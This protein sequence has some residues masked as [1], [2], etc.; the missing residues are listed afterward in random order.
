MAAGLAA[1]FTFP[2]RHGEGR[3]GALD[4]YRDTPGLLDERDLAAAQ[5]LADVAS[6]YLIN[7][8][9]R[10]DARQTS[11]RFRSSSL[12]DSAD[13]VCPTG[14]CC[15]NGSSTPASA[16]SGPQTF[17]GVLFVD[18]DQFKAVNDTHGH[19]VGDQLLRAVA[20]RLTSVVRPGDTLARMYGDEFV[21]LC[22]DLHSV[23]EVE[24][25]AAR[26]VRAFDRPVRPPRSRR[27]RLAVSASVG[28]AYAG[29]R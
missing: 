26:V 2:L 21:F 1:V 15:S 5:T 6:A 22:E 24:A 3:L 7:A 20:E 29:P 25:L 19:E 13:R 27:A 12:H 23:A 4:L 17:A 16:P 11:D 18:L 14:C 8:Q 9:S 10:E 28:L